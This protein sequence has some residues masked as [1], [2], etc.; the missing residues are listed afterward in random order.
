MKD[1]GA[2]RFGFLKP[3][4]ECVPRARSAGR[5]SIVLSLIVV[6]VSVLTGDL[7]VLGRLAQPLAAQPNGDVL[8]YIPYTNR[9]QIA[10]WVA[11]GMDVWEVR[12]DVV[13]AHLTAEGAAKL[14]AVGLEFSTTTLPADYA[15]Y[16]ACYRT[17]SDTVAFLQSLST[18]FPSLVTLYDV[19]DSWEKT[20]GLANRDLLSVR[21]TNS[22]IPGPKPKLFV[23]AEHHAREL[24]TPEVAMFLADLLTKEYGTDPQATWLLDE[25][26]IWIMPMANPDGHVQAEHYQNWRKNTD[27]DS[28][29]CSSYSPPESY[30]VDLNRNYGYLWGG[31]GSSGNPCSPVFHGAAAF[32][33][34]ETQAVRDLVNAQKPNILI[35][36]HSYQ[37]QILYPWS[38]TA[39]PPPDEEGLRALASR[40]ARYNGYR[41][42]QPANLLYAV[43]GDTTD[44]AYGTLGIP[45]YTFEIGG[46]EDGY[47]WPPCSRMNRLWAEVRDSLLYAASAAD[48]PYER[49]QGPDVTAIAAFTG[50]LTGTLAGKITL[51]VTAQIHD[52]DGDGA[53]VAAAE[54]SFDRPAPAGTGYPL[55]P[56]DGQFDEPTESV[57]GGWLSLSLQPGSHLVFVRGRDE[58]GHWGPPAATRITIRWAESVFLPYVAVAP[59]P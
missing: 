11:Q 57:A 25:R 9:R 23:V 38:S 39:Q 42:G 32:S 44:W 24:I 21:L 36:L 7:L 20:Q 26:E 13:V 46:P 50:T 22:A 40:M 49:A 18:T 43:T 55:S 4:L 27:F 12:E 45:S 48:S 59:P 10:G 34:P 8:A 54:A 15:D 51:T 31:V 17:Y 33:E 3:I 6:V 41:Y 16:P 29:T 30:G 47:F 56:S 1:S 14:R 52:P 35:S 37:K 53:H 19:G 28:G 2:P 58:A 5:P